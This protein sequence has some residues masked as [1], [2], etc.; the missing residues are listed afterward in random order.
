MLRKSHFKTFLIAAVFLIMPPAVLSEVVVEAGAGAV[1]GQLADFN[2]TR[3]DIIS[4]F[5][6]E[7]ESIRAGLKEELG[8]LGETTADQAARVR[9][10]QEAKAKNMALKAQMR[11]DMKTLDYKERKI[12]PWKNTHRNA[13]TIA[14]PAV[15][16]SSSKY[17]P[18]KDNSKKGPYY[19]PYS[20]SR[21]DS[22]SC[23]RRPG[24]SKPRQ[25]IR[26]VRK[27]H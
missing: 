6:R 22:S 13:A 5:N 14:V 23:R 3:K 1:E 8:K 17:C 4:Q 24:K 7:K 16:Q 20:S 26:K 21:R 10:M 25:F 27:S 11:R 9:L 19:R 2:R 12:A 18:L 15:D